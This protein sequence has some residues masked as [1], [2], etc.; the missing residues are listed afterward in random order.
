[1]SITSPP[2][3]SSQDSWYADLFPPLATLKITLNMVSLYMHEIA[4]HTKAGFDA[5]RPPFC[6]DALKEDSVAT[7][8]LSTA[9]INAL[10]ASLTAIDGIIN[11]FLDMEVYTLRTMP[12]MNF[13]R[14]SYAMVVLLKMYFSASAPRSDLATVIEKDNLKVDHYLDSLIEKFCLAAADGKSR[15]ASK[16]LVVLAMLRSWFMK[17]KNPEKD[18]K[19]DDEDCPFADKTSPPPQQQAQQQ[20]QQLHRT[21]A[22][23][24]PLHLLSEVATGGDP[25]QH[26]PT[27]MGPPQARPPPQAGGY[28]TS[29]QQRQQ[30]KPLSST[31]GDA[32]MQNSSASSS[33]FPVDPAMT[34]DPTAGL[35]PANPNNPGFFD[36]STL[37]M[38]YVQDP[39]DVSMEG[40]WLSDLFPAGGDFFQGMPDMNFFPQ[41]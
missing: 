31:S 7:E 15:P 16:F 24:T 29:D 4:L 12:V 6:P 17:Q 34:A 23:S 22:A 36:L 30:Q 13:V 35:P 10:S 18:K 9:H 41:Q 8:A 25:N 19:D 1:M 21:A 37:M 38:G 3:P 5:F 2:L 32:W 26:A 14:V 27:P 28:Y 40:P 20:Q 39:I 33:T 11:A